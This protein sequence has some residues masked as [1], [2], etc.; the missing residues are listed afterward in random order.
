MVHIAYACIALALTPAYPL[1][2][3]Y[4]IAIMEYTT[5]MIAEA[6]HTTTRVMAFEELCGQQP[7]VIQE[8]VGGRDTFVSLPTCYCHN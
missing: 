6:V 4:A 1:V 2:G 3:Q 5:R 8:Y 7:T